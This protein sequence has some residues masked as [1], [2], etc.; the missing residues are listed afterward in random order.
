MHSG[1][2]VIWFKTN[3]FD[4]GY[5]IN[6]TDNSEIQLTVTIRDTWF[7]GNLKQYPVARKRNGNV[8][9]YVTIMRA[10][11]ATRVN[12]TCSGWGKFYYAR[13]KA[14]Q[15]HGRE[16]VEPR[17]TKQNYRELR[18]CTP[19]LRCKSRWE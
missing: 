19:L 7:Y 13:T 14:K 3:S 10:Y 9:G 11:L 18:F 12:R 1:F 16:Q 5:N 8:K 2:N 17:H 4:H 15:R 6:K